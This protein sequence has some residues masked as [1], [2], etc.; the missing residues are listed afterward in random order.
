MPI[1]ESRACNA[2]VVYL[3]RLMK[4]GLRRFVTFNPPERRYSLLGGVAVQVEVYQLHA[5]TCL[6]RGQKTGSEAGE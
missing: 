2:P 4:K 5:E 3:P 1:C 6:D